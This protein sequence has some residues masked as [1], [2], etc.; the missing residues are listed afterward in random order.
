MGREG[1]LVDQNLDHG[2]IRKKVNFEEIKKAGEA[3]EAKKTEG[4]IERDLGQD[5]IEAMTKREEE[6]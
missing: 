5:E 2:M 6:K 4:K 1:E 3:I